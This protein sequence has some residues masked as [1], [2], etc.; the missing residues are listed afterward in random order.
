MAAVGGRWGGGFRL[1]IGLER[2]DV[3]VIYFELGAGLD[4]D[5][6]GRFSGRSG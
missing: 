3:G 4:L 6:D 5:D 2:G 1:V